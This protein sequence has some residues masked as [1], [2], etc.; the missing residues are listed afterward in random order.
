MNNEELILQ[1]LGEL[2][3]VPCFC[4]CCTEAGPT[5]GQVIFYQHGRTYEAMPPWA[6]LSPKWSP[7]WTSGF[8]P[9]AFCPCSPPP[10]LARNRG[11]CALSIITKGIGTL[12]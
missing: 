5:Y 12:S 6:T 9:N 11:K 2:K 3:A 4:R 1:M 7:R 10:P 8:S